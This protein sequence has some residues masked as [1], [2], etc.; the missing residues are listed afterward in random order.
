MKSGQKIMLPVMF[1]AC[2]L[3]IA[4]FA[5]APADKTASDGKQTM[6]E[7]FKE[8]MKQDVKEIKKDADG[9]LDA[10]SKE[11]KEQTAQT[12]KSLKDTLKEA[13]SA[14]DKAKKSISEG[15]SSADKVEAADKP[16]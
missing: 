12:K 5:Q 1:L 4:A 13:E 11:A 16:K 7:S 2:G 8:T 9:I 6:A 14:L 3:A 10:L 15:A